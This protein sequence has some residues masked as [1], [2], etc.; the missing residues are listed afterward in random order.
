MFSELFRFTLIVKLQDALKRLKGSV[1]WCSG[2]VLLRRQTAPSHCSFLLGKCRAN[3]LPEGR[4]KAF[5][6]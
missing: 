2:S 5:R 3:L 1:P 6:M 4:R